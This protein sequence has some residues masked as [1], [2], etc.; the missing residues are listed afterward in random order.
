MPQQSPLTLRIGRNTGVATRHPR[1]PTSSQ[2]AHRARPPRTRRPSRGR[3]RRSGRPPADGRGRHIAPDKVRKN[4]NVLCFLS[5]IIDTSFQKTMEHNLEE[6]ELTLL[7]IYIYPYECTHTAHIE[8]HANDDTT[9]NL[10]HI[11]AIWWSWLMLP[12][13]RVDYSLFF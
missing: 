7:S 8:E 12:K 4:T 13:P 2:H 6:F 9:S 3:G 11:S 1:T 10:L 5:V